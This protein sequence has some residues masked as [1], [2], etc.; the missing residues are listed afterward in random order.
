MSLQYMGMFGDVSLLSTHKAP[1][2]SKT[3]TKWPLVR[4]DLDAEADVH[5]RPLWHVKHSDL[6]QVGQG[7]FATQ[8]FH[9]TLIHSSLATPKLYSPLDSFTDK[10]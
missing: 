5:H 10:D 1:A 3:L 8:M 4:N 6:M 9:L 2:I 7:C